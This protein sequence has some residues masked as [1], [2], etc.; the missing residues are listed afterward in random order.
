VDDQNTHVRTSDH[1]KMIILRTDLL[2]PLSRCSRAASPRPR[3]CLSRR[4]RWRPHRPHQAARPRLSGSRPFTRYTSRVRARCFKGDGLMALLVVVG[5]DAAVHAWP[6]ADGRGRA[7]PHPP[8]HLPASPPRHHGAGTS[9]TGTQGGHILPACT[10]GGVIC[11]GACPG[12]D[13]C[14][15]N[16]TVLTDP[17]SMSR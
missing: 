9:A 1:D 2:V 4:A 10:V 13:M 5:A 17:L 14:L 16:E 7:V 12:G 8:G 15:T 3:L 11:S 6:G